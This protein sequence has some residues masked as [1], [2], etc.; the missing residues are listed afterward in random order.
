MIILIDGYNVLKIN[1]QQ[2]FI[3]EQQRARFVNQ[4]NSYA[5][6]KGHTVILVFDGGP[7]FYTSH[8]THDLVTVFYSGTYQ[9]ADEYIKN[10]INQH[11]KKSML[12]V[13]SDRSITHTAAQHTKVFMDAHDFYQLLLNSLAPVIAPKQARGLQKMSEEDNPELDTLMQSIG[14]VSYKKDDLHEP[15]NPHS[16]RN[17]L[18]KEERKVLQKIKKL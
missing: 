5:K 12:I 3:S 1:N 6:R 10:Y 11:S 4:L 13:S 17:K 18:S 8:E 7:S 15:A 9:S 14:T 2:Q 16:K